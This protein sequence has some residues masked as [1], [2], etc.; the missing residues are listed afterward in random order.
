MPLTGRL[1]LQFNDVRGER[2]QDTVSIRLRHHMLHERRHVDDH[3][4]SRQ[5][6]VSEL[7]TEPQGLYILEVLAKCYWP[8]SR[9]VTIPASGTLR[10]TITLPIRP[11]HAQAQF[12]D[13]AELDERVRAVLER[14]GQVLGHDG[15]SGRA[16][17]QALPDEAK[18][19]LLNIAKKSLTTPFKNGADLLQHITVREI[20]GDRCFVDLPRDVK[21]QMADLVEADLFR[22]VNGSLH[23][24][25]GGFEAAG[26]F[27]TLDAFGNL[28]MTFFEGH[29][30]VVADIDIDD[31]GGL[32]H[33]FQVMRNHLTGSPTHPYNI[34][35]I[36][37]QHQH[38]DPGY[39][40]R[41]RTT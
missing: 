9:F 37:V 20:R 4:A 38:L 6:T 2:I 13:Y 21:S 24:P 1:E 34:H 28:Q 35:Q 23:D 11:D 7:R 29:G 18:A 27:K 30:G 8:V 5:L 41:P 22:A 15:L 32:G 26:S 10:E 40:L 14:S 33:V 25:P 19:G 12:P 3:D 31:A 17:Y 39:Q 16:L 36:L